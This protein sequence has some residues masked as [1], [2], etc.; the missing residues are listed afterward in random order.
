MKI[1]DVSGYGNSGKTVITDLL[2][3]FDSVYSHPQSF[4]FNLLRMQGGLIDLKHNIYDNWSIIRSDAAL[5]RFAKLV[6]IIGTKFSF[7]KPKTWFNSNGMNYS[8]FFENFHELSEQYIQ[9]L[10]DFEI[11]CEWPYN[12]IEKSGIG[13]FYRRM[14]VRLSLTSYFKYNVCY[15][16]RNKFTEKTK[17]YL[18]NLFNQN[19]SSEKQ[20]IVTNNMCNPYK[21]EESAD[22]FKDTISIIVER[23]PRDIYF[24]NYTQNKYIPGFETKL[25]NLNDKKKFLG[26]D[27]VY[28]FAKRIKLLYEN[29]HNFENSNKVLR[30]NFEDIVLNYD[31]TLKKLLKFT[32]LEIEN[33]SYAK[34]YFKPENSIKNIGIWKEFK[35]HK[36]FK[37]IEKELGNYLY[38]L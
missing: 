29:T 1:I 15:T 21:P 11:E 14:I 18:D 34:K 38:K 5:K 16:D 7:T 2:K 32:G 36:D 10:I 6:K 25:K 27:N 24:S 4:E 17:D 26:F 8:D 19:I 22:M 35:K 28:T 23:D 30:L 12:E 3:E 20:F 37:I 31:N 9:S 33:H 13:R